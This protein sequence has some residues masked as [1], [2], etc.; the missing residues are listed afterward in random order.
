MFVVRESWCGVHGCVESV[1][2]HIVNARS[3]FL[4][5]FRHNSRRVLTIASISCVVLARACAILRPREVPSSVLRRRRH[6][7]ESSFQSP[8]CPPTCRWAAGP[9]A[10]CVGWA[11]RSERVRTGSARHVRRPGRR[12][13]H[14]W[15]RRGRTRRLR[16][17]RELAATGVGVGVARPQRACA[18]LA[19]S[20]C[21]VFRQRLRRQRAAVELV[22]HAGRKA[23]AAGA[24]AVWRRRR[25]RGNAFPHR[26]WRRGNA[27]PHRRWRRGNAFPH[28]RRRRRAAGAGGPA[29][30]LQ[31]RGRCSERHGCRAAAA[32]AAGAGGAIARR[33]RG[34]DGRARRV[35]PRRERR[36]RQ[37]C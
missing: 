8:S 33:A 35:G 4:D 9:S 37:R 26:R 24:I 15:T 21:A 17:V 12:R 32:G 36:E 22:G 19:C 3:V 5:S 7:V 6:R 29:H 34:G 25:R 31:Q 30:A 11:R 27:F 13:V 18:L 2:F 14:C 1:A 20:A 16:T 23:R 10:R 28:R